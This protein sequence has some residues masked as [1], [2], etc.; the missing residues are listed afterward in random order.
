MFWASGGH[1]N[2]SFHAWQFWW[3]CLDMAYPLFFSLLGHFP[4]WIGRYRVGTLV[5]TMTKWGHATLCDQGLPRTV[6]LYKK[7]LLVAFLT[8][9]TEDR[10]LS[11]LPPPPHPR[12]PEFPPHHLN[13]LVFNFCFW[14]ILKMRTPLWVAVDMGYQTRGYVCSWGLPPRAFRRR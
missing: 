2:R 9:Q 4:S 8:V 14:H 11:F 13:V 6:G 7:R 10:I 5:C 1:L 3:V 12:P